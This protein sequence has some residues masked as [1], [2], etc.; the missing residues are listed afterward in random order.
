M[1]FIEYITHMGSDLMVVDAAR[2]SFDKKSEWQTLPRCDDIDC[3]YP[4]EKELKHQDVKLINYLAKHK[5]TSP[6]RHPQLQIRVNAPIFIARQLH[7][8]IIGMQISLEDLAHNEISRRY[9]DSEPEFFIPSEW[10]G[11]PEGSIK[12]G[13]SD[14]VIKNIDSVTSHEFYFE[15]IAYCK[16]TYLAMLEAGVAPEQARMVL[17]QSMMTSWI[18]T[19]SLEAMLHLYELRHSSHA[20]KEV[21]VMAEQLGEILKQHWPV[22]FEAWMN[23]NE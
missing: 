12:Q 20:Q 22:S 10:R 16:N 17:P 19:G 2:V 1:K 7:K 6:F 5:H 15:H 11:R 3:G 18:W 9:V 4:D 13:S 8:H 21:Q 23:R 14:E